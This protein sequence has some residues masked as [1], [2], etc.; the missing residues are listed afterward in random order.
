MEETTTTVLLEVDEN[1]ETGRMTVTGDIE[2]LTAMAVLLMAAFGADAPDCGDPDCPVH[3]DGA[4]EPESD[5]DL[6]SAA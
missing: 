3:G 5:E 6:S 2:T 4:D 1:G